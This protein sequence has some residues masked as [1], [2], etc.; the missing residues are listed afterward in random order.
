MSE[1]NFNL[2][3]TAAAIMTE[4]RRLAR[5]EV[6]RSWRKQGIKLH[7]FDARDIA[8]AARAYLSEHPEL[9]DQARAEISIHAQRAKP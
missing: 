2:S 5:R 9:V 4:A 8:K 1:A 7:Q 3:H 6:Q